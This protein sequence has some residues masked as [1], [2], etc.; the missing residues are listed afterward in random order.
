MLREVQ[1][2]LEQQKTDIGMTLTDNETDIRMTQTHIKTH[3]EGAKEYLELCEANK[4]EYEK[5]E[6][7][8]K[9]NIR[10]VQE[11]LDSFKSLSSQ[12]PRNVSI[13]AEEQFS[14]TIE[15]LRRVSDCPFTHFGEALDTISNGI[16]ALV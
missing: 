11:V 3:I 4:T 13:I 15:L 2:Y 6:S 5:K 7:S 10:S 16:N 14:V 9:S 12:G 1:T 8:L